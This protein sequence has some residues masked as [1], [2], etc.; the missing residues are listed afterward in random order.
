MPT[1]DWQDRHEWL[2]AIT[3]YA[4]GILD[5]NVQQHIRRS[6]SYCDSDDLRWLPL[7]TIAPEFFDAFSTYYTSI[8]AFHGCRPLNVEAYLE[9]GFSGHSA[10]RLKEEFLFR[11]PEVH[12]DVVYLAAKELDHSREGEHNKTWFVLTETELIERCGTYIVHGSEYLAALA[13]RVSQL[14][15]DVDYFTALQN[16]G[17]PT[18]IEVELPLEYLPEAQLR[19]IAGEL[20]SS[21]GRTITKRP[22]GSAVPCVSIWRPLAAQHI[23]GHTH[24]AKV[25][26]GYRL[27][28]R[29][30]NPLECPAC[31][32]S[33]A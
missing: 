19:V 14:T 27:S 18:I 1:L 28:P 25:R 23:T 20:L 30:M 13:Q 21:W 32:K 10:A 7:E 26:D 22:F 15:H 3:N 9:S 31:A 12:R 11:F 6:R 17:Y 29:T 5:R 33:E 4:G 2:V 24:P 8:R 16:S